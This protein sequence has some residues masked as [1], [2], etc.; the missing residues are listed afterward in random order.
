MLTRPRKEVMAAGLNSFDL[1][2]NIYN[3]FYFN[4]LSKEVERRRQLKEAADA[5]RQEQ[6]DGN[7]CKLK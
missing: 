1:F 6:A 2:S 7:G 3:H 4:V 5:K